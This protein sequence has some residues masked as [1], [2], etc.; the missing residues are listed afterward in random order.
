MHALIAKGNLFE[1]AVDNLCSEKEDEN[2]PFISQT[3]YL[4]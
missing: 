2:Q 1:L 4:R 3:V